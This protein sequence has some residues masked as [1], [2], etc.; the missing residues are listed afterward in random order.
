MGHNPFSSSGQE[1]PFSNNLCLEL[2]LDLK[3]EAKTGC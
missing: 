2:P 3:H 1:L